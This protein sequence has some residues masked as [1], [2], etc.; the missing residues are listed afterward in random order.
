[1]PCPQRENSLKASCEPNLTWACSQ[2][3]GLSAAV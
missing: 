2:G 3:A 1:M